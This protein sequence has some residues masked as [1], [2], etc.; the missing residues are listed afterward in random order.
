MEE[1][2]MSA[3]REVSMKDDDNILLIVDDPQEILDQQFRP[4]P[5]HLL[6]INMTI[7]LIYII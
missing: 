3:G 5:I 6:N 1:V 7:I 2:A 4:H